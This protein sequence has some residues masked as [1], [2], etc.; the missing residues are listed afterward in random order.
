MFA[1]FSTKPN[2]KLFFGPNEQLQVARVYTVT[3][4]RKG[5]K[6]KKIRKAAGNVS[7]D[8]VTQEEYKRVLAA[9]P[10]RLRPFA[11]FTHEYGMRSGEAAHLEWDWLKTD[12]DGNI[13]ILIPEGWMKNEEPLPIDLDGALAEVAK[14]LLVEQKNPKRR[15]Y[16]FDAVN[17]DHEWNKAA[18][19]AGLG[20]WDAKSHKYAGVGPHA[21]RHTAITEMADAGVDPLVIMGMTGHKDAKMVSDYY[22]PNRAAVRQARATRQ[23]KFVK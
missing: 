16:I 8:V 12:K 10:E 14:E 22:A 23:A 5:R 17:F 2:G 3:E 15:E 19:A 11:M 18:S 7:K 9:L 1:D 21:L 6:V 4:M 20:V 13:F